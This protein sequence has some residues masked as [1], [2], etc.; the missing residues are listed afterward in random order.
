[1]CLSVSLYL[2]FFHI[3]LRERNRRSMHLSLTHTPHTHTQPHTHTNLRKRNH[4]R[5]V[6]VITH[7]CFRPHIVISSLADLHTQSDNMSLYVYSCDQH[8]S[9][10]CCWVI[11]Y[12]AYR[13]R[14]VSR[15]GGGE[16]EASGSKDLIHPI[17]SSCTISD[18]LALG[19]KPG[20]VSLHF[21]LHY[22]VLWS[23]FLFS[24]LSSEYERS[25]LC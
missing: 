3:L 23:L 6:P 1:M 9:S 18:A 17:Y 5:Y 7:T 12:I 20:A 4:K 21:D 14:G 10:P 25:F 11:Y 2:S 24:F 16:S 22:S 8:T 19:T 15:S 13:A